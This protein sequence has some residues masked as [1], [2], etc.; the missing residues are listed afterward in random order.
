MPG[1]TVQP[2]CFPD[3]EFAIRQFAIRQF[4]IRGTPCY[5]ALRGQE[6]FWLAVKSDK[7]NRLSI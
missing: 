5:N 7:V 2:G 1:P 4:A 3:S 6:T